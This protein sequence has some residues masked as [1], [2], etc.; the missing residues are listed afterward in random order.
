VF[1]MKVNRGYVS[2]INE[3]LDQIFEKSDDMSM[4]MK[5]MAKKSG[6]NYKTVRMINNRT[7]KCPWFRTVYLLA[8][9]VG[10]EL[11]LSKQK[12][13]GGSKLVRLVKAG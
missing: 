4:P 6:V 5:K 2:A 13:T 10:M 1:K 7:T 8:R 12:Q 11:N 9:S 3:V